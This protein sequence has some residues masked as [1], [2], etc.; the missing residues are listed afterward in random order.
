AARCAASGERAPW[1]AI[2]QDAATHAAS[3][4]GLTRVSIALGKRLLRSRMDCRVKPGNDDLS[5]P[6]ATRR[7]AA[8]RHHRAVMP[9]LVPGI[10]VFLSDMEQKRGLPGRARQ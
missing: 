9:S 10:Y 8:L 4:A 7:Y 2:L 5:C 3:T 6:G 1:S